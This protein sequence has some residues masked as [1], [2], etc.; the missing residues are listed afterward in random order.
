MSL[1]RE[2]LYEKVWAKPMLEVAKDHGVSGNYLARVCAALNVP[3]PPR[4]YW[5]KVAA[6]QHPRRPALPL[7]RPG[8]QVEWAKGRPLDFTIRRVRRKPEV[9]PAPDVPTPAEPSSHLLVKGAREHFE[10]DRLTDG[11]YLRPRKRILVDLV[12]SKPRLSTALDVANELFLSLERHGHRVT[13]APSYSY[14]GRPTVEVEGPRNRYAY[15]Y[16]EPWRPDRPTVVFVKDVAFGLTLYEP[17][18]QVKVHYVDGKYVPATELTPA[19][20]RWMQRNHTWDTT[21]YLPVGRLALRAWAADRSV[22]WREEWAERKPG[23]LRHRFGTIRRILEQAVPTIEGLV[24]KARLEAEER[25][26]AREIEQAKRDREERERQEREAYKESREQLLAIVERWALARRIEEFF[27]DAERR[28]RVLDTAE[29]TALV[30]RLG[31][32]REL[33]G[34]LDALR[35][36]G[37]WRSPEDRVGRPLRR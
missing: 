21:R 11:G 8:D 19:H 27:L 18:E 5:A 34:T 4:G 22:E 26:K 1:T 9:A 35:H 17:S 29:R 31:A 14:G 3:W 2:A 32:A 36:F 30:Q 10:I 25:R 15:D 20:L 16:P 33:L 23:D 6:G 12:V 37:E 24:E 13:F 7:P 28:A